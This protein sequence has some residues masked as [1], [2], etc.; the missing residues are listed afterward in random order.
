MVGTQCILLWCRHNAV[1]AWPSGTAC[2]CCCAS[3]SLLCQGILFID[4]RQ[5]MPHEHCDSAKQH[6]QSLRSGRQL[7]CLTL[8]LYLKR[9]L[10]LPP[11]SGCLIVA[12]KHALHHQQTLLQAAKHIT[13]S[14]I[15]ICYCTDPSALSVHSCMQYKA[16]T[17]CNE[18]AYPGWLDL[19]S[20]TSCSLSDKPVGPSH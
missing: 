17:I 7:I 18:L 13:A 4:T 6:D 15:S 20:F 8:A 1:Q 3:S 5:S 11:V 2:C 12:C 16:Q 10:P 9:F 19:C 14:N